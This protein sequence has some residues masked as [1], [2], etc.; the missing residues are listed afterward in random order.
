MNDPGWE[1]ARSTTMVGITAPILS[2]LLSFLSC[3]NHRGQWLGAVRVC[4]REGLQSGLLSFSSLSSSAEVDEGTTT[5]APSGSSLRREIF[6]AMAATIMGISVVPGRS[7]PCRAYEITTQGGGKVQVTLQ[8]PQ[9]RLGLELYETNVRSNRPVVA[10]RSRNAGTGKTSQLQPGMILEDFDSLAALQARMQ[11]EPYPVTLT[12][13]NLAAGGDAF[14][15]TGAPLVTAQ[16]ALELAQKTSS[17]TATTAANDKDD[18][19]NNF[20]IQV[21]NT[22]KPICRIKSRRNDVLEIQ[23]V[24]SYFR[25]NNVNSKP[26]EVIY[27]ASERRGTGQPYQMVLGSGDMLPGVDLG[28][29]DMCPG[30]RR[31]LTIPPRLAYGLKGN[32]LFGIPPN[33]TLVW[34][35]ELV[36]INGLEPGDERNRD[37]VEERVPYSNPR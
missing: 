36:R 9:D 32:R 18:T 22:E 34:H 35:V 10:I 6:H 30:E 4:P 20:Q 21:L 24:A 3:H 33:Q 37:E 1:N 17:N 23:Y 11:Q 14:S 15:D 5:I 13:T 28:L 12:F 27:D 16:D 31:R 29:Y 19:T 26:S 7:S 25:N 2:L 8:S